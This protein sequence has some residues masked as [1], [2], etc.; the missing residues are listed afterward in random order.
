MKITDAPLA[1]DPEARIRVL[2]ALNRHTEVLRALATATA[3]RAEKYLLFTNGGGVVATLSFMGAL[4]ALRTNTVA[5]L[6]L[7][8]FISG[9]VLCGVLA[10]INYHAA[11]VRMVGWTRD[12]DRFALG[13]IDVEDMSRNLMKTIYWTRVLAPAVAYLAF[14]AFIAA[15]GLAVFKL[16]P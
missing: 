12:F 13:E 8:P 6:V 4:P 7:G 9:V 11:D 5:W 16:R 1:Q 10:A 14:A 3:E 15:S 2:D